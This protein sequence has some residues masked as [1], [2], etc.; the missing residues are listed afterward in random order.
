[1][2]ISAYKIAG[3]AG[4]AALLLFFGSCGK[5]RTGGVLRL[6]QVLD[7]S[8]IVSSPLSRLEEGFLPIT[9]RV[10][11]R[12][13]R[14][15]SVKG[16]SYW[17]FGSSSR[18]LEP[19]EQQPA[20]TAKLRQGSVEFRY[21]DTSLPSFPT[22]RRVKGA[23]SVDMA[24]AAPD[25][26]YKG[27][28]KLVRGRTLRGSKV[29]AGGKT[30]FD[31]SVRRVDPAAP[32]V[33]LSV[34]V[35]G[36]LHEFRVGSSD[37][38]VFVDECSPG[39]TAIEVAFG[40]S[41]GAT[42]VGRG[43]DEFI[44]VRPLWVWSGSDLIL[45]S[46]PKG[47]E[48]PVGD[49]EFTF[50]PE[51]GDVIASVAQDLSGGRPFRTGL[52]TTA[53]GPATL[54]LSGS[55]LSGPA[56]LGLRLD[57]ERA[58]S[59]ELR[60]DGAFTGSLNVSAPAGRHVLELTL[61][62]AGRE[63]SG[64]AG[65]ASVRLDSIVW[66]NPRT[67]IDVPLYRIKDIGLPDE[68][69]ASN[70]WNIKKKLKVRGTSWNVLAAPSTT[71]LQFKVKVP[72]KGA[73]RFGY[74][75]ASED[76]GPEGDGVAFEV[77]VESRSG[78]RPLFSA[79][80]D[81]AHRPA[82]RRIFFG[83]AD[84]APYAGRSVRLVFSTHSPRYG[85]SVN[86]ENQDRRDDLAVWINPVLLSRQGPG[87]GRRKNVILISLDA[88]R[89]DH[90]GCYG[91]GR[92]TS[93]ALD[94]LAADGTL[95]LNTYS[96]APYTLASHM[97][98]LT[99]EFPTTHRV[100][101]V[102]DALGPS[103]PT[104]AERL[105]ARGLLTAAFTGGGLM[106]ARYG[107]ARG[108]DEFHDRII[109][110]EAR[111]VVGPLWRNVSSWLARNQDQPFFVFLHTYQVHSPYRAPAPLGTMFL[112]KSAAWTQ[113]NLEQFIGAGYVHK[114]A[115]L[116]EPQ[117]RNV[118]ALYDGGIRYTD[119]NLI[120]PLLDELKRLGL[121][122]DTLL[123][124]TAD[125]GE[126]FFD[127]LTWG[128][129]NTLYDELLRVPMV[130]RFP[131]GRFR[132]ARVGPNARLVDIVPT[133]LDELG[134]ARAARK[135]DGASLIPLIEGKETKDR[136]CLS[137]LPDNIFADPMPSK[138]A[139]VQGRYKIILNE[140][141]PDRAHTYFTPPPPDMAPVELFDLKEDPGERHNL[142]GAKGEI[143]RRM[144]AELQPYLDAA[145]AKTSGS[146]ALVDRELE[147][148]LRALGYVK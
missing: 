90:L 88:T 39:E 123:I 132:G 133:V 52:V 37:R 47:Q 146:K 138:I 87:P 31:L 129:S 121:Y 42:A 45:M 75:L 143:V 61:E 148:R 35:N 67:S 136:F 26:A 78:R 74:G 41:P 120:R 100:F 92:P 101:H 19:A 111:D 7:K 56:R 126:E 50:V 93:P 107:Y 95:F 1:M 25:P 3:A 54:E 118:I 60:G 18:L 99:G 124:I 71:I 80:L 82:D 113:V 96:Q 65:A 83:E 2:R 125:H 68:G 12:D 55:C 20:E 72:E 108:F 64:A 109:S 14:R 32:P 49:C 81:P 58:G 63:G 10:E 21:S 8:N 102:T 53:P 34:T 48:A 5:P 116:S 57:A 127:H 43:G 13:L 38:V 91:Y 89:P 128:H 112:D 6:I 73:L 23:V 141:Y 76:I 147:E 4:T 119:E 110:Q 85:R 97:T 130:M 59:V 105:Q 66:R 69:G 135:L 11:V 9:D 142:V 86:E 27:W 94:E 134:L 84:L 145:K 103:I 122:D 98:M 22:W 115:P 104:L 30:V 70:P 137:Y 36:R 77:T 51:P 62:D 46:L 28:Y 24:G 16:E 139:L 140:K 29:L 114:Y 79:V 106:D 33:P 131:G 144:I 40:G 117:R 15:I 44:L 17:A